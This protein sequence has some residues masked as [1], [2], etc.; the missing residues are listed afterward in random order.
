MKAKIFRILGVIGV[1][2]A[3]GTLSA[4]FDKS[5]YLRSPAYSYGVPAYAYPEY[6]P[7]PRA[8]AYNSHPYWRYCQRWENEEHENHHPHDW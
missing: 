7:V 1:I 6:V 3:M 5:Y 8:Y 4:C 2:L